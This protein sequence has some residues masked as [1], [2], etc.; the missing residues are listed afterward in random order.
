MRINTV[1]QTK[2]KQS[3]STKTILDSVVPTVWG[4]EYGVMCQSEA[5]AP[6]SPV[7]S[8]LFLLFY[9]D[10][11]HLGIKKKLKKN[12]RLAHNKISKLVKEK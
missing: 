1:K 2:V 6:P 12:S 7:A 9:K 11:S 10:L 5:T 4:R 3:L 8:P